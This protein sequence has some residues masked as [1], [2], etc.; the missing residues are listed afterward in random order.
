MT[1]IAILIA[2][3]AV[4]GACNSARQPGRGEFLMEPAEIAAKDDAICKSYG[5]EPGSPAYI[6]CRTTQDQRRDAFKAELRRS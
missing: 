4:L 2:A 5:A 3:C 6:Q 1:R